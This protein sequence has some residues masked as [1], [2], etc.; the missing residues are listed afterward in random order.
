MLLYRT[1][2]V[3]LLNRTVPRNLPKIP[4]YT[5][6]ALVHKTIYA[7]MIYTSLYVII[8]DACRSS[9]SQVGGGGPWKS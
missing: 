7:P 1:N 8:F 4:L 9:L 5:P 6:W 3:M 2:A